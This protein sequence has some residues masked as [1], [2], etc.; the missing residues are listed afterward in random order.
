MS[1]GM[2]RNARTR[3]VSQPAGLRASTLRTAPPKV[4]N[5]NCR[6]KIEIMT[7]RKFL[8]RSRPSKTLMWEVRALKP[9]KVMAIMK[10]AKRADFR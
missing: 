7:S 5:T 8:F 1:M 2:T 4:T 9:L 3:Q 10:V 6:T